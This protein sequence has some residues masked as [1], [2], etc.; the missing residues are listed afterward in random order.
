[1]KKEIHKD[2]DAENKRTLEQMIS[3]GII[4]RLLYKFRADDE[5]SEKIFTEHTLWFAHPKQFNDPFDCWANIQYI[6]RKGLYDLAENVPMSDT[7]KYIYKNGIP[8]YTKEM[9]KRDIDEV[10]NRIGICSFSKNC[11]NI[12][13][14]SHYAQYHEG[15]CLQ[16]DTLEDPSFFSLALPV[17]YVDTMPEYDLFTDIIDMLDKTIRPKSRVW[18]YEEEVRIIKTHREIDYN[19]SQAFEF[20]PNALKKIIFGCKTHKTV[21]E[22]YKKLCN[23][24][25]FR[26]I[27][28]SQMQQKANGE[29]KL[30]E[31]EIK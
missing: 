24:N 18:E 30:D 10:F 31:I 20:T 8:V 23:K 13:M 16:F 3:D 5:N 22:K 28:F 11:Q 14:W 19:K 7:L 9:Y 4:N 17:N 29:Y 1:M 12:L 6:N 27:K 25:G 2:I 15:F 21:I 26:H